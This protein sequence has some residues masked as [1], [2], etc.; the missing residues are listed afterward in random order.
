MKAESVC[1]ASQPVAAL[2]AAHPLQ[3]AVALHVGLRTGYCGSLTTFSS[4]LLQARPSSASSFSSK[5]SMLE[6]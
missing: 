1:A 4:W 5:P 6:T 2:P 3:D